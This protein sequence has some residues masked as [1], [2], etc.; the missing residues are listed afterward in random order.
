[1]LCALLAQACAR[2]LLLSVA[3]ST[4]GKADA[5]HVP[6]AQASIEGLRSLSASLAT[7]LSSPSDKLKENLPLPTRKVVQDWS[8]MYKQA[9]VKDPRA[10]LNP[11]V[12]QDRESGVTQTGV[13]ER[14]WTLE[15]IRDIVKAAQVVNGVDIDEKEM[16]VLSSA[17]DA[18]ERVSTATLKPPK[19]WLF[20]ENAQRVV[21]PDNYS[22]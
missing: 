8:A 11:L 22:L 9:S 3:P 5:S 18:S 12:F 1:M 10:R 2:N 19:P 21:L 7:K 20:D 17:V 16:T 14:V 15:A 6:E 4:E 13:V